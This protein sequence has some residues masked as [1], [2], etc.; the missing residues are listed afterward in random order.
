M[1]PEPCTLCLEGISGG[2]HHQEENHCA[3]SLW[4]ADTTLRQWCKMSIFPSIAAL[5]SLQPL[6][7]ELGSLP[8]DLLPPLPVPNWSVVTDA[9]LT[10]A[11]GYILEGP[12]WVPSLAFTFFQILPS[13]MLSLCSKTCLPLI[14]CLSLNRGNRRRKW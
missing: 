7:S 14:H 12:S 11:L 6:E 8:C 13:L 9:G 4:Q 2:A 10:L 3:E 1:T 5:C